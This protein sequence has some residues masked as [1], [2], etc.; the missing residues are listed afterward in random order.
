MVEYHNR[1]FFGSKVGM[2]LN[3]GSWASDFFYLNFIKK[4]DN[5]TWEKPSLREGKSIKFSLEDTV[6]ILRVLSREALNWKTVHVFKENTTHISF[7][8]DKTKKERLHV[9]GGDYHKMLN[10]AEVIVFRSLL[11]HVFTEKIAHSTVISKNENFKKPIGVQPKIKKPKLSVTEQTI[12]NAGPETQ[13]ESQ[14]VAQAS[15]THLEKNKLTAETETL[16]IK[17]VCESETEKALLIEFE[18]ARQVWIPKSTI[19]SRFDPESG[20]VQR[21]TID[22]WVLKKNKVVA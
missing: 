14:I 4:R 2:F 19:R 17:G 11:E 7:Q 1:A 3:S 16:E 18:D 12:R 21:F 13:P 8:W 10:Y 15:P 9:N 20:A 22:A 5:G 6:L